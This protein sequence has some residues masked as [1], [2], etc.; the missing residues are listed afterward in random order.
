MKFATGSPE[1]AERMTEIVPA[2]VTMQRLVGVAA[3]RFR[4][5]V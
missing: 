4:I 3:G 1:E 5:L 2:H